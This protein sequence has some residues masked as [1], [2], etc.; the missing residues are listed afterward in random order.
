MSAGSKNR[1]KKSLG[2]MM[3]PFWFL[4]ALA[5]VAIV[6]AAAYA[7]QWPVFYPHSIRIGGNHEVSAS[8]IAQRAAISSNR[9]LWLQNMAAAAD[10]IAALPYVKTVRIQRQFPAT[11]RIA[12]TERVPY[13]VLQS[14]Q[15]EEVVDKDFR[16]LADP[17]SAHNLA[18]FFVKPAAIR[19]AG[20]FVTDPTAL[21][22]R[23][24]YQTLARARVH[25]THLRY[26]A[27][28][29]L[30]ASMNGTQLLL[31][32]ETGLAQKAE[33]IRPILV[34]VS[35]AGRRIAALDLRA[36]RTPVVSYR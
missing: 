34:Q 36:P 26:D 17:A 16:V 13:A 22:L 25:V 23:S 6:F 28:G 30:N 32:S 7:A 14:G 10:R 35:Q 31:G 5:F 20:S 21:R 9:N 3:R 11:V 18:V 29:D 2:S 12:V 8:A 15:L 1:R 4:G 27:F 33:L 19:P 24:D